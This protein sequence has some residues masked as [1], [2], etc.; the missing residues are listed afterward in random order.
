MS[1]ETKFCE[2]KVFNAKELAE[3][4]GYNTQTMYRILKTDKFPAIKIGRDYLLTLKQLKNCT[5]EKFSYELQEENDKL[6][7]KK[8]LLEVFHCRKDKFNKLIKLLK[9]SR[10]SACKQKPRYCM[11]ESELQH[12]FDS[13]TGRPNREIILT[14]SN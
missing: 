6:L 3:F 2:F 7:G 13:Y 11:Y 5:S 10:K 12:W 8:E 1:K 14:W 4:L 9:L